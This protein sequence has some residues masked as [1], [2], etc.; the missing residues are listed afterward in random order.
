MKKLGIIIGILFALLIAIIVIVPLV[1]DVDQYRPQ[2]QTAANER[3]N[4][5][6]KLGKLALSLWGQIRVEV[7]GVQLLDSG[8]NEVVAVKDAFFHVP[9]FSLI[10]GSPEL[11]FK[12]TQ[13]VIHVLKNKAGKLNVMSLMK[14]PAQDVSQDVSQNKSAGGASPSQV[15]PPTMSPAPSQS[16]T[17]KQ[18][19]GALSGIVTR[20]RLGVELRDALVTYSD[21]VTG[22]KTEV[23]ELNLIVKDLS[24]SRPTE[25]ELWANLDTR[26][27][28]TFYL[29]GPAKLVGNA[30]PELKNGK[31]D[32]VKISA[33]L[34][35]NE[36]QMNAP[37][38]FEKKSGVP[39]HAELKTVVSEN[40]MT[41]D[42][43]TV[44]FFNAIVQG[45]GNIK[46]LSG[47]PV[48]H[49]NIS[50][51]EVLLKP[52]VE[53]VP[54]LKEYELGGSA[55]F[56][57][58]V[59]G[60]ADKTDYQAKFNVR[61]L[62]AKAPKLKV[63]P[64][65][66]ASIQVTTDRIDPFVLTMT[67]P[68]NEMKIQG[69]LVSFTRPLLEAKVTS[70]G[71]DLDQLMDFTPAQA[72]PTQTATKSATESATGSATESEAKAPSSNK[73]KPTENA[74]RP[75]GSPPGARCSDRKAQT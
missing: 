51:N 31:F 46:Q 28:K 74:A 18:G 36:V 55:Q 73:S 64:K 63:Q 37:G 11:T 35:M 33:K 19:G 68:G 14:T 43:L 12:M 75:A 16:P 56:E 41:L 15:P 44:T 69:K 40:E 29:K 5:N 25:M 62:T 50:S 39:T 72:Q 7:Q 20:A 13:P 6:L 60:P 32:F 9:F 67:A 1:V 2:I 17:H 45:K 49:L 27:G 71:M 38:L 48:V 54:M 30:Q 10:S 26:L 70:S 59:N 66:N 53:L 57:A 4:G 23:K 58:A 52:W 65:F 61:E 47:N 21:Q 22:F 34:D 24:L 3:I 8:G 42:N